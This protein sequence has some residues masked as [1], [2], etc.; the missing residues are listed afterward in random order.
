MRAGIISSLLAGLAAVAA[1]CAAAQERAAVNVST[2]SASA[3]AAVK[4]APAKTSAESSSSP[5]AKP[6]AAGGEATARIEGEK[7]FKSNCGRC[8]NAPQKFPPRMMATVMRHM[9]VKAN[10]TEPDTKLILRYLSE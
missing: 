1:L 5:S 10:L 2:A 8:H 7:R 9:R 4:P 6:E 3:T